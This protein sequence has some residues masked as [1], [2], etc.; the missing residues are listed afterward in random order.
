MAKSRKQKAA[1]STEQPAGNETKPS[2][3][4]SGLD[5]APTVYANHV[6][7]AT[8]V[9][10]FRLLLGEIKT[11]SGNVA[12]GTVRAVVFFSPQ[13]AKALAKI[14]SNRVREY[15]E[16]YGEINLEVKTAAGVH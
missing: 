9:Y 4:L 12:T 2:I 16:R 8:S 13:H 5:E 6:Q 15:E 11:S 7:L 10:D 14:L 1:K 3:S